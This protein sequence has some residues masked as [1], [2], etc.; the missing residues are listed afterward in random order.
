[1]TVERKVSSKLLK[2]KTVHIFG[3]ASDIVDYAMQLQDFSAI[4]VTHIV[5]ESDWKKPDE[6]VR[7][8]GDVTNAEPK[9]DAVVVIN[10]GMMKSLGDGFREQPVIKFAT[11]MELADPP[12]PMVILDS[13][14]S[15]GV[16]HFLSSYGANYQEISDVPP[17]Q[18]QAYVIDA[19]EQNERKQQADAGQ[20][21]L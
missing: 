5:Q 7:F 1:M 3:T 17:Y 19:I 9:A 21:P 15:K 2:D 13:G 4:I 6:Y 20:R 16:K 11:H 12:I 8:A 10:P 14:V 18:I